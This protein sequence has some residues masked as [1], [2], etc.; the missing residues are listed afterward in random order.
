M[1]QIRENKMFVQLSSIRD[2]SRLDQMSRSAK[3]EEFLKPKGN[4]FVEVNSLKEAS[5]LC[6]EYINRFDL[7]GSNWRG[8]LVVDDNFNFVA[9]VSYNGRVWDKD[10]RMYTE[11]SKSAKE[12][13]I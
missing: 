3:I 2:E 8:G 12:I 11:E 13:I 9:C 5:L 7:G 4:V 1:L 10:C 6:K